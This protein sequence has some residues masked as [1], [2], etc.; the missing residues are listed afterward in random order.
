MLMCFTSLL[1][2]NY[3]I[4]NYGNNFTDYITEF[5]IVLF[6]CFFFGSSDIYG[7]RWRGKKVFYKKVAHYRNLNELKILLLLEIPILVI[8]IKRLKKIFSISSSAH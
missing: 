4:A 5:F 7:N 1:Y 3:F 2:I 6:Y 8:L